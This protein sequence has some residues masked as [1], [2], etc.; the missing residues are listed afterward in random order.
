MRVD[1]TYQVILLGF[2]LGVTSAGKIDLFA[3]ALPNKNL[4]IFNTRHGELPFD[5]KGVLM[6]H[7]T[8][9]PV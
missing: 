7:V 1:L 8:L 5:R 4:I 2:L 3:F 6:T 9:K